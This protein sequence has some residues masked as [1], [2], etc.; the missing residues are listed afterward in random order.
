[1]QDLLE[2]ICMANPPDDDD[3]VQMG[4]PC[5]PDFHLI[6]CR[7]FLL[8]EKVEAAF[9]TTEQTIESI[10]MGYFYLDGSLL[11]ALASR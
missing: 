5:H 6:S 1:M 10:S 11:S 8:L 4:C 7:G 2:A 3:S 9:W